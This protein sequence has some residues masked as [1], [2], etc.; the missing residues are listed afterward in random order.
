MAG[1]GNM[2]EIARLITS[3]EATWVWCG[4]IAMLMSGAFGVLSYRLWRIGRQVDATSEAL[5]VTEDQSTFRKEFERI[6]AS[7]QLQPAIRGPWREFT[8]TLVFPPAAGEPIQAPLPATSFFSAEAILQPHLNFRLLSAVPN[9]LTGLGILGTFLGL[10]FGIYLANHGLDLADTE[11]LKHALGDLL[12][13]ASL[14]FW[15]SIAGVLSAILFTTG[16]RVLLKRSERQIDALAVLVDERVQ[17]LTPESLAAQQLAEAREQ[18]LQLKRFN[19]DLAMSIAEA[20]DERVVGRL[21]PALDKLIEAVEG[22]RADRGESNEKLLINLIEEFKQS[23]SGAAGTEMNAMAQ[24]L[25]DLR[26]VLASSLG[27]MQTG[28][29][30]FEESANRLTRHL[31]ETLTSTQ[32]AMQEQLSAVTST[33]QTAMSASGMKLSEQMETA[34]RSLTNTVSETSLQHDSTARRME[35]AIEGWAALLEGT[36]TTAQRIDSMSVTLDSVHEKFRSTASSIERTG[37][38]LRTCSDKLS[39]ATE[40]NGQLAQTIQASAQRLTSAQETLARNWE[41]YRARFSETDQNLAATFRQLD[42]GLHRYAESVK[43]F[44]LEID[45]QFGKVSKDLAAIVS[46]MS[47]DLSDLPTE[48]N[49]LALQVDKLLG[50]RRP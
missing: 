45:K 28:Q 39:V 24:T 3:T 38:S 34:G 23:L 27:A 20:L 26:N 15:T 19:T 49:K 6:A 7:V 32:Q 21:T 37:E 14:A 36:S 5:V 43:G 33:F 42:D 25:G 30:Q 16:E 2:T 9:T 40:A 47:D 17:L 31:D 8:K 1:I 12:A 13:G 48:V 46:T 22:V 11:A 4:G 10:A 44:M 18:T 41:D 29:V 35:K 50:G